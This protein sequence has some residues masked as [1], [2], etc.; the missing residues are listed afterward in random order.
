MRLATRGAK[1]PPTFPAL[2]EHSG[3][4]SRADV[5]VSLSSPRREEGKTQWVC[6]GS[7]P[8]DE[9]ALSR[10]VWGECT[11]A[12][13]QISH[14]RWRKGPREGISASYKAKEAQRAQS[15]LLTFSWQELIHS[16]TWMKT[17]L[18]CSTW[19]LLPN[20]NSTMWKEEHKCLVSAT[21]L[22]LVPLK[23]FQDIESIKFSRNNESDLVGKISKSHIFIRKQ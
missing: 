11:A 20:V 8:Q 12:T 10:E 16:H 14:G 22:A 2:Q 3:W 19:Q 15:T 23:N 4:H 9:G 18:K 13:T 1:P 21:G 6:P 17:G 5:R 7:C